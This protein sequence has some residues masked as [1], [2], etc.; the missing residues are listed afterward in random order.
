MIDFYKKIVLF[1]KMARRR[2][3]KLVQ[4]DEDVIEKVKLVD[5]VVAGVYKHN[6]KN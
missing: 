3:D 6:L 1:E 4:G 2:N 5:V